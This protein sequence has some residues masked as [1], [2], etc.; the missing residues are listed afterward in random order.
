MLSH[1]NLLAVWESSLAALPVLADR[2]RYMSYLPTA[3]I[4]DRIFSH[5]PAMNNGSSITCVSDM[6]AAVGLLP[7]VRPTI[8]LAVPRIWE[9]LKDAI[10]AMRAAAP[11]PSELTDE[12]VKSALGLDSAELLVSGAAPIRPD[13]LEFFQGMGVEICE[14][15]GMTESTGV[16][17]VNVPGAVK[18]GTVGPASGD[19]EI[20]LAEDDEILIRGGIVM[21]GYRGEP[22]KTAETV[23][24]DGWLHTGDIG[25][26]DEDGYI[27]IVDRKKELIINAAGKN[28][29]PANIESKIK[30][31]SP[32]IA[33]AVAIGDGRRYNTALIALDPDALALRAQQRGIEDA[34]TEAMS[35][36]PD[37]LAEIEAGIEQANAKMSRV[38]QIKRWS[39]VPDLWEPGGKLIT[40]TVKLKRKPIAEEYSGLI[41]SMYPD[42]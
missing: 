26:I 29:S 17:A 11:D 13:V 31:A 34:S 39:V 24:A 21:A 25:A 22:E 16:G 10:D 20:E 32:L 4:A 14:G 37:L 15:Y 8:W 36:D 35:R 33:F 19:I 12:V 5:Y 7:S 1:G 18:I 42:G 3:H 27:S 40:P 9:K 2:G 23:D 28:M 38:E 41:E 30:S 6:R